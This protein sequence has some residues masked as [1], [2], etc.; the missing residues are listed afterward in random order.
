M[1]LVRKISTNLWEIRVNLPH[2]IARVFF[3]IENQTMI[4]LHGF[5]KKTQKTPIKELEIAEKRLKN[6]RG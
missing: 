1:P 3:T 4:L 5:I 2:K 6:I